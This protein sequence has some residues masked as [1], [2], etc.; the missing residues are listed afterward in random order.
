MSE[1]FESAKSKKAL[2]AGAAVAFTA[3]SLFLSARRVEATLQSPGPVSEES[4]PLSCDKLNLSKDNNRITIADFS[5]YRTQADNENRPMVERLR[6]LASYQAYF[7]S[8]CK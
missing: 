3:S 4:V 7:T 6:Y 1:F 5:I 2:F 8:E